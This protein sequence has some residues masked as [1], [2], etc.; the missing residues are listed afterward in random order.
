MSVDPSIGIEEDGHV[1]MSH[2]EDSSDGGDAG[3]SNNRDSD[4][5]D[6]A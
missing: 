5:G 1:A 3:E 2:D 4:R 6:R